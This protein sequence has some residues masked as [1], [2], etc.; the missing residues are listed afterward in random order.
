MKRF[1]YFEPTS[2]PEAFALLGRY[3]GRAQPL[4]GGTDLLVELKEHLRSADCVINIKKI[5][6][7]DRLSFDPSDGL[8]IGAL[9]TAREIEVSPITN[10]HYSSLVQATRELGSIQVRNRATIAGNVCRASPSLSRS[11]GTSASCWVRSHRLRSAPP[12]GRACCAGASSTTRASSAPPRRPPRNRSR[13]ATCAR[14][15]RTDAT[16]SPCSRAAP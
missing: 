16:W 7:I 10:E 15:P 6:G 8:Y 12:R 4:A 9:V 14:A 3:Q 5:P 1:E 2:L 11:T 13:S